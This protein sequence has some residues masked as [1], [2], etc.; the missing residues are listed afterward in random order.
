VSIQDAG[1]AYVNRHDYVKSLRI[2]TGTSRKMCVIAAARSLIRHLYLIMTTIHLLSEDG[3][4][5]L[6]TQA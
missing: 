6:A 5:I 2:S 3:Y 1:H 4:V